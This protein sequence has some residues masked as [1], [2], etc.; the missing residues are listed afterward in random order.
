VLRRIEHT[1]R[2]RDLI[3]PGMHVIAGVSGGA[4]SMALLYAL[5]FLAP[6]LGFQLSA[7]H[8]HHGLRGEAADGDAALVEE[9]C[10][11]LKIP[12]HVKREDVTRKRKRPGV[13]F[14]MAAREARH[15]FFRE[16]LAQRAG[17]VVALAHH[18]DDQ[19]ETVLMRLLC[20]CGIEGLGGMDYRAEPAS[21]LPVIRPMLD[22]SRA[23]IEVFLRRFHLAWREDH[24]NRDP[25]YLRN[26]IRRHT[27]PFLAQNG[28]PGV[29]DALVR[30]ADIMREEAAWLDRQTAKALAGCLR[31]DAL[32]LSHF[33][34]LSI[35]EQRRVLRAWFSRRAVSE[36]AV[37]FAVTERLRRKFADDKGSVSFPGGCRVAWKSGLAKIEA[38]WPMEKPESMTPVSIQVPGETLLPDVEMVVSVRPDRG[39]R[40]TEGDR[41][42]RPQV[43]YVR[44]MPGAAPA[45]VMR[46]RREG[47]RIA[48]T[49]LDGSVSIKRLLINEKIPREERSRFPLLTVGDEVVWVPGYR[50]A[51]AWAVPSAMSPSWRIELQ[52]VKNE[53]AS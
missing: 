21:G 20:G 30:L 23:T 37:D 28:F 22:V 27:V 32:S 26:R 11:K 7:T 25:C 53:R 19:A 31:D 10:A 40:R 18:R 52:S 39:F 38:D 50:V 6:R 36:R 14:E 17:D 15:D 1:I 12:C 41:S 13:S 29:T 33:R 4:D 3:R 49:G 45:F 43:G 24:T 35:A 47:D 44:R 9:I 34:R 5:W 51:R 46:S 2:E 8:L 16:A 42:K 48:P